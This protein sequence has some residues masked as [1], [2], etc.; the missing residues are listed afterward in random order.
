[1]ERVLEDPPNLLSLFAVFGLVVVEMLFYVDSDMVLDVMEK[2]FGA[3]SE[4]LLPEVAVSSLS[5]MDNVVEARQFTRIKVNPN[6]G[7]AHLVDESLYCVAEAVIGVDVYL[8]TFDPL[9]ALAVVDCPR[10]AM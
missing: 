1:M 8:N 6:E 9:M 3:T 4:E 5:P 7:M 2:K 10:A